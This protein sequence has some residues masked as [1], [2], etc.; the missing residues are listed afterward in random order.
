[1]TEKTIGFIGSGR[2]TNIILGGF[3]KSK[4]SLK[5]IMVSDTS[6]ESL[7]KLKSKFP[8]IAITPNDNIKPATKDIVFL[9]VHPQIILNVLAEIKSALKSNAILISLAPRFS[10]SKI[11]ENLSGFSRIVRMIP[12]APSIVNCGYNP[13]VYSQTIT[14]SEK[15]ELIN[16]FKLLGECPEVS[17][18]KLEAYAILTGMGPTYF[19]FQFN[20]LKA[21]GQSF[22]LTEQEVK[23]SIEK[24]VTGALKTLFESDLTPEQVMDLI[25]LRPLQDYEEKIKEAYHIKLEGLYKKMKA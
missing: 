20:E 9:A 22:G 17:E 25:P 3:H 7:D 6:I 23:I 19:W 5:H 13:V 21:I 24:M 15:N 14:E 8:E 18:E 11:S 1:M 12:N 10:I 16:L 4:M 2:V